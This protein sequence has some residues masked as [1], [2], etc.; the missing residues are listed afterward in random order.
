ML[1]Q[2]RAIGI[3]ENLSAE[4]GPALNDIGPKTQTHQKRPQ[5]RAFK[6]Y[7]CKYCGHTSKTKEEK[8]KHAR[9]HIP[10]AKQ[11]SCNECSFVTSF[12]HHLQYHIMHHAQVKPFKCVKCKYACASSS[13]LN[14][15]M[16][17]LL[18]FIC[19]FQLSFR[20]HTSTYPYWCQDCTYRTKYGHSLKMHLETYNHRRMTQQKLDD[21]R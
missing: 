15:H 14:S 13:A 4:K 18:K 12:K 21:V 17:S 1:E 5:D 19:E 2:R 6:V 8:W 16:K 10:K 9:K 11:L 3:E 7:A 20:S